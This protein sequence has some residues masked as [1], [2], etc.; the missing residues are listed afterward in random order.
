MSNVF[1]VV[2]FLWYVPLDHFKNTA[3]WILS[4]MTP[5]YVASYS[6]VK[7]PKLEQ[8]QFSLGRSWSSG[9]SY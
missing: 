9:M 1:L 7:N 5:N 8:Q 6:N 2:T 3:V 4:L